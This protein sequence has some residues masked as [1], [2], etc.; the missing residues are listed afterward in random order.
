[1]FPSLVLLL[2]HATA[3]HSLSFSTTTTATTTSILSRSQAA[4][5]VTE[6]ILPQQEYGQRIALG[7][8]A[9]GISS[10]NESSSSVLL[11]A[12]DERL[13]Q[14]YGEFPLSSLDGLLDLALTRRTNSQPTDGSLTV[15]DLGSGC[16]RLVYYLGLSRANWNVH[17]IE[18]S[19][20]L[21]QEALNAQQR[22]LAHDLLM[23]LPS[24]VSAT[25]VSPQSQISFHQGPA[26]QFGDIL[27]AADI[28]FAYSTAW[29]CQGFSPETGTMILGE[30][31]NQLLTRYCSN[32][33]VITT[34]RSLD[35]NH[36]HWVIVDSMEVPNPEVLSSIGY[37]QVCKNAP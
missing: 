9:Q 20:L 10:D 29:E 17:G 19:P 5:A 27:Q 6:T 32:A 23:S 37:L 3:L 12:N 22:A 24:F 1:M 25:S 11:Q 4:T 14:T 7:R 33:L 21:H 36:H 28:V 34:D 8:R 2:L 16:G 15:V 31:W 35:S 18:L 13:Y 30:E 26:E